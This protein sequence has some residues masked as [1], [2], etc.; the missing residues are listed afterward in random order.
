M[1]SGSSDI[2]EDGWNGAGAVPYSIEGGK[3]YFLMQE[4]KGGKKEGYLVDFGG[5]RNN[6]VDFSLAFCA[7]R[8]FTEE[9]AGLFTADD[10]S[11]LTVELAK[12]D[13]HSIEAHKSIRSEVK[14][15]LLLVESAAEQGYLTTSDR[16]VKN[17]YGAYGIQ[18]PH[19]D[20][21]LPNKFFEDAS[22]RKVRV[23]QWVE[24]SLLFQLLRHE[25]V[26]GVLPLH[27]RVFFLTNLPQ[28]A[29]LIVNNSKMNGTA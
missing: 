6:A 8:E 3:V 17:W 16:N 22:L 2:F 29:Q 10:P 25:V 24:S 20:L 18:L 27:P 9:T 26:P 15:C 13:H 23:F 28:I 4:T 5:G 7:A 12:L 19:L 1:A 21:S 14:R 11:A